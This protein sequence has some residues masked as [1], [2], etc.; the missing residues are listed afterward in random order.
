MIELKGVWMDQVDA[1]KGRGSIN[2]LAQDLQFATLRDAFFYVDNV[3]RV[4]D[5]DLN[6][7][8]KNILERKV[9]EF[10]AWYEFSEKEIRKRYEIE[11]QYLKSQ[12]GT[13]KNSLQI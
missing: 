2:L 11:R 8:V 6:E 3:D 10:D 13:L 12:A 1:K 9:G 5:L 7:R 4:K